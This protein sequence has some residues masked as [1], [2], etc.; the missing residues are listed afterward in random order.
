MDIRAYCRAGSKCLKVRYF[1]VFVGSKL[2]MV[3]IF[4]IGSCLFFH[5][6]NVAVAGFNV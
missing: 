3:V 5:L 4:K 2:L 1:D 6:K